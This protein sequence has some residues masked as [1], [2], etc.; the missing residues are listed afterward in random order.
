MNQSFQCGL[1]VGKFSPLH[2]GHESLIKRALD[3]C[4]QVVVISY[5][6][7][8]FAGCESHRRDQWF[9]AR[10]PTVKHLAVTDERLQSWTNV[11]LAKIPDNDA[12]EIVHR[13]FCGFLC[14]EVLQV[15]VDAVF[16]SETYGEGFA[17]ELT[18]YFRE[19]GIS[20]LNVKHIM[21][22]L[23]RATWPISGT[24]VRQSI[25]DM[26]DWLSPEIYA[27]FVKKVCF[28]GGESTG[29]STLAAQ[30]AK[31]YNT[32]H[33]AEYGR[34]LWEQ[35][36]GTLH[37]DDLLKIART[38]T[39]RED[40]ATR[41][42]S[43]FLF[44]DTSPLTTL[45]YSRSLFGRA[46]PLIES[47]AQRPYDHTFLCAPDF[48]FDQDGTR[49]DAEF[50]VH[51]HAW[52]LDQ[53]NARGIEHTLLTGTLESRINQVKTILTHH[54]NPTPIRNTSPT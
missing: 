20:S 42:A 24:R 21:V 3:S 37:Y 43:E 1:V 53:L 44:C 14:L 25:H 39:A 52:Y 28:L 6:K 5:S 33:V 13:R 23:E 48:Q 50:R 29:K 49:R 34:E 32:L 41:K 19:R 31:V 4:Q 12:A 36:S 35:Q 7:P 22:D 9:A 45:F 38:Q 46:D 11:P 18:T 40:L 8:E 54:T 51:Q 27:T 47:F 16:T 15:Q 26:R 2:L 30:L 10:Y 17:H